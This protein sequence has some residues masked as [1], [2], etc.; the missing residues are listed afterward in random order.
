M[1]KTVVVAMLSGIVLGGLIILVLARMDKAKHYAYLEGEVEYLK[2]TVKNLQ[3]QMDRVELESGKVSSRLE[4]LGVHMKHASTSLI[5]SGKMTTKLG[6]DIRKAMMGSEEPSDEPVT[7][8]GESPDPE[9]EKDQN[10]NVFFPDYTR[11]PKTNA[12]P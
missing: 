3:I 1:I 5:V 8:I 2:E 11:V 12:V 6:E 10:G 7:I 9:P 4:V